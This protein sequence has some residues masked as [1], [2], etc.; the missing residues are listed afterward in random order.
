LADMSE[1]RAGG[2][3]GSLVTERSQVETWWDAIKKVIRL[4]KAVEKE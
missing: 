3:A 1:G 2:V 4:H